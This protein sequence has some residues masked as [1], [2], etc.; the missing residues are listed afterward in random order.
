MR[1]TRDN[2]GLQ[3][4]H[5]DDMF[6]NEFRL[7][8]KGRRCLERHRKTGTDCSDRA[9]D[10]LYAEEF[11][12]IGLCM[13]LG[14]AAELLDLYG[15]AKGA[16]GALRSVKLEK[17]SSRGKAARTVLRIEL[18]DL[19]DENA[20]HVFFV[21]TENEESLVDFW[22]SLLEI[23]G[24]KG[25]NIAALILGKRAFARAVCGSLVKEGELVKVS[26]DKYT[27][28]NLTGVLH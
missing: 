17:V 21:D 5:S 25:E 23:Y 26:D 24:D 7:T 18:P 28:P 12:R 4:S 27:R 3:M 19:D 9:P 8:K 2:R 14:Q 15:L 10:V 11:G 22:Y 1:Q 20:H 13:T 16:I 6:D